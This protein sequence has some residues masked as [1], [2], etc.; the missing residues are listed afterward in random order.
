LIEQQGVYRC[1]TPVGSADGPVFRQEMH[2]TDWR[3]CGDSLSDFLLWWVVFELR[4][5][6]PHTMWGLFPPAEA[7][8][9]TGRLVAVQTGV[10]SVHTG[11]VSTYGVSHRI[12]HDANLAVL[13]SPS[14]A[15]EIC[16]EA[17]A[18]EARCLETLRGLA[19]WQEG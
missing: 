8:R 16:L 13:S 19:D 2:S 5:C 11:L 18:R 6:R 7:A 17:V 9:I 15:K 14:G 1:G 4:V 10:V 3:Q 12:W